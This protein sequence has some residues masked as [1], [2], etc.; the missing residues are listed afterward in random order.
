MIKWLFETLKLPIEVRFIFYR[1]KN[2][3]PVWINS[4]YLEVSTTYEEIVNMLIQK[5][6][7]MP[8]NDPQLRY[9]LFLI[10]PAAHK[11]F[12]ELLRPHT[13]VSCGFGFAA[14]ADLKEGQTLAST[15]LINLQMK[16]LICEITI[17]Q[18]ATA[19]KQKPST[20]P[21]SWSEVIRTALA[22]P[23]V[24]IINLTAS[25]IGI[26]AVLIT[27]LKRW[28]ETYRTRKTKPSQ[29]FP[30]PGKTDIYAIRLRMTGGKELTMQKWLIEPDELKHFID[31]FNQP[32]SNVKPTEVVFVLWNR[33]IMVVDVTQG[34]QGN[35]Q[36][37]E[38]LKHLKI[39]PEEKKP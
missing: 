3:K 20:S 28:E 10:V 12:R 18:R 37:D 33:D 35:P 26:T 32:S 9:D 36:L 6:L 13:V 7:L 23:E 31:V 29:P 1:T 21:P 14:F 15:N 39:D 8:L 16:Y 24:G 22:S 11:Q 30:Q 19:L 27:V 25:V 4:Y 5:R 17:V 38:M 2:D 34:A